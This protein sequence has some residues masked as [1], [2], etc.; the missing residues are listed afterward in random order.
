MDT[1]EA[2]AA[3][4]ALEDTR[5]GTVDEVARRAIHEPFHAESEWGGDGDS[6]NIHAQVPHETRTFLFSQQ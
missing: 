6:S 3:A 4:A 5:R 1:V 2:A